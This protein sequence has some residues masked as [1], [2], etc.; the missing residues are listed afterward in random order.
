MYNFLNESSSYALQTSDRRAILRSEEEERSKDRM[1]NILEQKYA[2]SQRR[3][4]YSKFVSESKNF[5]LEEALY[6]LF[7]ECVP[8]VDNELSMYGKNVIKT[9]V[10]EE[11]SNKLLNQFKTKTLFL[12]ELASIIESSHKQILHDTKEKDGP[13]KISNSSYKNFTNKLDNMSTKQI[14][15]NIVDRVTKAEEEFITANIQD[16]N[17]MEELAAKTKEKIDNIKGS[18][19]ELE[20]QMKQEHTAMYKQALNKKVIYRKKGILESIITS[21]STSIVKEDAIREN[22]TKEDGK[23]DTNRIIEMGEV[24][25][26]VLEMLNTIKAKKITPEYLQEVILSIK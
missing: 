19:T 14:A 20:D 7:C 16:K 1:N 10:K 5:L 3:Q 25:Y 13:F 24:M 17:V 15:K 26:T 23:L 21:M 2:S 12:S 4:E 9:F 6:H 11:G 22:F 18:S 8:S